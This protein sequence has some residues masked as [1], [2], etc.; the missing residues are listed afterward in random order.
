MIRRDLPPGITP[1]WLLLRQPAH[2]RLAADLARLWLPDEPLLAQPEVLEAIEHHDDGWSAWEAQPHLDP[3]HGRPP[4]FYEMQ[5][6]DSLAIWR[7]S[8]DAATAF[9]PLAAFMVSGHFVKLLKHAAFDG[10]FTH[11]DAEQEELD[12]ETALERKLARQ[13][14]NEQQGLQ[15]QWLDAW[16]Q[17]QSTMREAC[18]EPAALALEWLRWFDWLSL[19][20]CCEAESAQVEKQPPQGSEIQFTTRRLTTNLSEAKEV[21]RFEV[22]ADP[23]P[24]RERNFEL[25]IFGHCIPARHY[26]SVEELANVATRPMQIEWQFRAR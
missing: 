12:E 5:L 8:I 6:K 11:D 22:A 23:W 2:A 25:N 13:F 26:G 18:E 20:F 3:E 21:L 7:A 16:C 1:A 10:E 19:W 15:T 9:G 14:L 17:D 24:W 4:Q